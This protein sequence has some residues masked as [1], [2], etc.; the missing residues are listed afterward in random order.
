MVSAETV[1]K[2]GRTFR[3]IPT[4]AWQRLVRR[5]TR[6][7]PVHLIIALADHFE[8]V[9]VP[10]TA[11]R[12]ASLMAQVRRVERWGR[13]YPSALGPWRDSDGQPF[14]HTYFY[15][16]EDYDKAVIDRLADHCHA[17]WGEIEIHLH[18]GVGTP[19][20]GENT[21]RTLVQFRDILAEHGCLSCWEGKGPP[22]YA[23]V[24]GNW[25]LANSMGGQF[26]GVDEEMQ[27][28]AETGCYADFTLPSAP[29]PTQVGKI[30]AMYECTRPLTRRAPHRRGR[31]LACG[32]PPSV[33]PII[34][35]GPLM[36]D[37]HRRI[38]GRRVPCIEN[39][40]LTSAR[41]PSLERLQL[42]RQAAITV[43]GRPEWIFIKLHCHGMDPRDSEALLGRP[44]QDFL[45][46]LT[47]GAQATADYRV[48]FVTGREMV[49]IVLAACD[50]KNGNPGEYR[51]YRLRLITAR[52]S[53]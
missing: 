25:A 45:Q 12:R 31:N 50:G 53:D 52:R 35:Q 13:A 49:N 28:L 44:M 41:P 38:N 29:D 23:F 26:C 33:F 2:V 6:V 24:H 36:V 51:D 7:R 40:A 27:I 5:P 14:R 39:S 47:E 34:V 46:L 4:Y 17:G 3:W 30:N 15:P 22:R 10:E 18:H 1:K 32:V 37:Y 21:R 48:H 20:T 11:G 42:W 9:F 43:Q 16:A 19:D 8:P